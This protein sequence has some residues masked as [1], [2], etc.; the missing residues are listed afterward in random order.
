MRYKP[1]GS[2]SVALPTGRA[3]ELF[4]PEGERGWVPGWNPVYPDRSASET[5]G[6]IFTTT[7]NR[8]DTTWVIIG[9]DRAAGTAAY[10]RTTPGHH[11]G[12]VRVHCEA[13]ESDPGSFRVRVEYDMTL[14]EGADAAELRPYEP[15]SFD[16][17]MQEW[18]SL[19]EHHL[20]SGA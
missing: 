17:V 16:A 9:I 2:F 10:A 8:V 18:Q 4:T 15:A 20:G 3:I 7:A 12:I 19:L 1:A 14:L 13:A 5:P 11:A 6:T